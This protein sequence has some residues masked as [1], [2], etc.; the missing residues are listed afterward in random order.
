MKKPTTPT[1]PARPLIILALD[2]STDKTG[3]VVF[4]FTPLRARPLAAVCV[5]APRD[6]DLHG[7]TVERRFQRIAHLRQTLAGWL[8]GQPV[9][10]GV[11][12][13]I[14][15][16]RGQAASN[17]G[18]EAVGAFMTI[19]GN[20]Q[21]RI[22][23]IFVP[24]AKA[25]WGGARLKSADSKLA[26]VRWARQEFA[27]DWQEGGIAPLSDNDDAIA[28]A[29]AVGVAAWGK[30]RAEEA[31]RLAPKLVGRRGGKFG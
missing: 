16:G 8:A 19:P 25:V 26:V 15:I 10:D 29:L 14:H 21:G 1:D 2:P 3:A 30:W 11:A 12:Y 18:S 22:W 6:S 20:A 24:T 28:D 7:D 23:G 9:L 13:E 27:K 4:E 31:A 17:A 5:S